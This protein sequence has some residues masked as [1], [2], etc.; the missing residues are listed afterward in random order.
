MKRSFTLIELLVVIAIIA[1]LAS[2]LLPALSKARE[3]ARAISCTN[4]LKQ[5]QLGMLLYTNDYD[6]FLPPVGY[7]EEEATGGKGPMPWDDALVRANCYMWFTLNPIVPGTPMKGTEWLSKDPAANKKAGANGEDKGSWH[8]VLDCPSCPP[9]V[10][11]AG[12]ISYGMNVTA[13]HYYRYQKKYWGSSFSRATAD[14]SQAATWHRIGS[15]RT[16]SQFVN[17]TDICACNMF[18]THNLTGFITMPRS[19]T[20]SDAGEKVNLFRH[21]MYMNFSFGD[22][23]VEAVN[24]AKAIA[25]ADSPLFDFLWFPGV[26]CKGGDANH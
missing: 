12:N 17:L 3:K 5:L 6:D 2:M 1:I 13:S 19:L 23:H 26:D 8:K 7:G 16:A 10:R 21:S 14:V 22:G 15:I 18:G 9:D 4:N 20:D 24:Q 25:G 11:V